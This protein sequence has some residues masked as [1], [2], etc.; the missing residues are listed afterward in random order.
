MHLALQGRTKELDRHF[1]EHEIIPIRNFQISGKLVL[2][3]RQDVLCSRPTWSLYFATWDRL[4]KRAEYAVL[5]M[6]VK[7]VG[8]ITDI[9]WCTKL[10]VVCTS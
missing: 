6:Y 5:F 8:A 2:K 10:T 1:W 9:E 4:T 7:R 3:F